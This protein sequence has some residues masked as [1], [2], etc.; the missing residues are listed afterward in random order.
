[1]NP[2]ILRAYA[3]AEELRRQQVDADA[4]LNNLYNLHA[5]QVALDKG[6]NGKKSKLEYPDR[7][8]SDK[9]TTSS[10]VRIGEKTIV[11]EEN[12]ENTI[13]SREDQK[14]VDY[15]FAQLGVMKA[16]WEIENNMKNQAD[17]VS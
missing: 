16:N 6:F 12:P 5:I 3:K 10:H 13:M 7:P 14:K 9:E 17:S 1:M 15:L 11:D 8:F 2:R 4:W